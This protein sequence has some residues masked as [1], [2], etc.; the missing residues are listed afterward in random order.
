MEKSYIHPEIESIILNLTP[1][2][3]KLDVFSHTIFKHF[4]FLH[5]L[6][7]LKGV[8]FELHNRVIC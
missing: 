7:L 6:K 1:K 4:S 5:F 3:V 2:E 8:N